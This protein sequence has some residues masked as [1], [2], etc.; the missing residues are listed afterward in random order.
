VKFIKATT[1]GIA[2]DE[3]NQGKPKPDIDVGFG[4]NVD[5][6]PRKNEHL[7]TDCH[8]V[9]YQDVDDAFNQ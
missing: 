6:E 3:G 7:T 5:V 2:A 1:E 9:A 8:A 4:C